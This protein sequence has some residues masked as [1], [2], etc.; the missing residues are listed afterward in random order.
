MSLDKAIKHKKEKRKPYRGSKA[1][2]CTCRN[3]GSCSYCESNRTIFDTK[4]RMR[5]E[6]Q[7]DEWFGYWNL[8]DPM[9][10]DHDR[11]DERLKAIGVDPWDFESLRELD[12]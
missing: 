5:L 2:D 1:I 3:H 7:E 4:A 6:G 11:W 9:D 10:V 12:I 8:P